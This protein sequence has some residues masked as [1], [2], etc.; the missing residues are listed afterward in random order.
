MSYGIKITGSD[1]G[2]E[3]LVTDS[4]QNLINYGITQSGR[5]SSFTLDRSIASDTFI[6]VK[7]ADSIAS[8]PVSGGFAPDYHYL[9]I[10]SGTN[11]AFYGGKIVQDQFG[12]FDTLDGT[13]AV[14]Y[15][16]LE[17]INTNITTSGTYGIQ[18]FT[19]TSALAFDSRRL[20]TNNS[21]TIDAVLPASY[22]QTSVSPYGSPPE[23]SKT[24]TQYV[25]IEWT[26]RGGADLFGV[27]DINDSTVYVLEGDLEEFQDGTEALLL[28]EDPYFTL[29]IA[30]LN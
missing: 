7:N 19:S 8:D 20:A 28:Y 1:I 17:K 23:I 22:G 14:D 24:S 15:A 10:T 6:F 13:V 11:V 26:N 18:I 5:A 25:N 30:T 4:D 3:Y 16:V 29:L 27:S 12:D 21:I 2:G 9:S